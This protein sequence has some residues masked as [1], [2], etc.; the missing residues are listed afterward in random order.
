MTIANSKNRSAFVLLTVLFCLAGCSG[1]TKSDKPAV[2]SW[3]LRP[4]DA[5]PV[6]DGAVDSEPVPVSVTVTAVA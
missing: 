5:M 4:Y 3:W 1:L 2:T 6:V